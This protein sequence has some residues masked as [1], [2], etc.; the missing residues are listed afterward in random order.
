MEF[1]DKFTPIGLNN[2]AD[3][4]TPFRGTFYGNNHVIRNIYV[5]TDCEGGLFS[6]LIE[7]K[8]YN[9]GVENGHIEST[10]N[11][12]CGAIAGEHHIS[13][14]YNCFARGTFEFVTTHAQQGALAAEAANGHFVN[15][16][17]TLAQIS[18]AYPMDG[19]TQNSYEGV[20]AEQ[21]A[22][23]E[24]CY[25]LGDAFRQ[26]IGADTYPELSETSAPVSYVGEA[27]Y[28]T[29]FD[30]A[31][32]YQLGG[33]V[34]AYV[35]VAKNNWLNLTEIE[36]VPAGTPVILKGT[37][38]NKVAK[39]VSAIDIVNEL[40][41]ATADTEANGVMYVLAKVDGKVGFYLAKA[42][43]TIA[44][45]KAYYEA[46]VDTK[47]FFFAENGETAI[48]SLTPS[49]S[50]GD[51]AVYNLSGQRVNKAQKGIYIVNGKKVL[52]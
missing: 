28:A 10:A 18:C 23:G 36:N 7:G 41:G 34:K 2:D 9:L 25:K 30:A 22:T 42:G 21:A 6:R 1:S 37:F 33:D 3:K 51:G 15:C 11:L 14:M 5:K 38:Y 19:S 47:A 39:D 16:Y 44:A 43:T 4:S 32:G 20:T 52:K 13:Y 49:L 27:G 40:K 45:G 48:N 24:L 50:E 26:T 8:I 46:A 12:R 35:A 29:F 31:N 17:T